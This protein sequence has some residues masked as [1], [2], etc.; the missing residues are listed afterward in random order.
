MEH[1]GAVNDAENRRVY[2]KVFPD[3]AVLDIP[4]SSLR[5]G[6]VGFEGGV[7]IPC[8]LKDR[9]FDQCYI[10]QSISHNVL[11]YCILSS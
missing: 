8:L 9:Y 5:A 1:G 7:R 6:G 2:F 10:L 4:S 3:G 11:Q